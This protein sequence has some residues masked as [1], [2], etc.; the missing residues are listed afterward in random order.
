MSSKSN[1]GAPKTGS[2]EKPQ[3][4]E[5]S[6]ALKL[7]YGIGDCGFTLMTNVESYYFNFFLTNLAQFGMATVSFITTVAS[8][9]DA[10]LS[11]IYGAILN[12]IKPKKWGRYRSWLILLPWIV[13]FLYAFQFLKIGDGPLSI[14]IIIIAAVVSHVV[15]NFPYVANVSMIAVAGKTP[16]ARSQLAS[17]RAA[18]ANLSK[19]IFSY[20]G[21]PLAALFA[22]MIG[23]KSQYGATA[24]VLGCVMAVAYY[25]HFK[26]FDGY[27]EVEAPS[28]ANTKKDTTKTGGKDLIK[29]LLQN[30]PLLTLLLADLAKWMFNFVCSGVAIYYFTYVA[31]DAGLLAT[32]IL[33]SNILC[34]IGSYLAKNMAKKVSTRTTTIFTF[35][36]MA[37]ILFVANFTYTNVTM[38]IVLMSVA[39]FG[40]GIAY[41]CTPA[42]YADTIIYSEWKTGKNATGWISGL[43]NVPLKVG[44]MT[45]GIIISACLAFASFDSSIDAAMATVELKKGICMAFM[46]IPALALIVA[47]LLLLFGFRLTKEKVEQYSAEIASRH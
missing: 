31:Q 40:Y 28:A 18:W 41:A 7:F 25:A 20:V 23:E 15:W 42:L 26:M 14:A 2:T 27:E 30:P 37:A 24:F 11:W 43:Q 22:G 29:A 16:D 19:V 38:V 39:Q 34:V 9:I 10:C 47:A 3:Q 4:K 5:L 44:V 32:Y 17:T 21:P 8:V 12:S 13:P 33:V 35:F 46:V 6:K 36:A 1:P 45:R